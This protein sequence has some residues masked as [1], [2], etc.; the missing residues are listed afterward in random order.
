MEAKLSHSDNNNNVI[1]P[2]GR[3]EDDEAYFR[4]IPPGWGFHPTDEELI[5]DYLARM[6]KN[7]P[8]PRNK[9][10]IVNLY[11]Y[12]PQ[13]LSGMCREKGRGEE[14]SCYFFTPTVRKYKMGQRPDRAAKDGYWKSTSA[15]EAIKNSDGQTVGFKRSLVFYIGK[16]SASKERSVKTNWLM[17]E[18]RVDDSRVSHRTHE[19]TMMLDNW[20]LCKLYKR[21]D[22]KA[23]N[24]TPISNNEDAADNASEG[25]DGRETHHEDYMEETPTATAIPALETDGN[26][27]TPAVEFELFDVVKPFLINK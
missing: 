16:S 13:E 14:E 15:K 19:H 20:V 9:I 5:V 8:L 2:M 25:E 1:V 10:M 4:R 21:V 12:N 22:S 23:S 3:K 18:Y 24:I 7:E 26:E 6:V 17:Q 11:D 27:Q